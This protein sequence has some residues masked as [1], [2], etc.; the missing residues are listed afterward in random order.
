MHLAE[1]LAEAAA[2]DCTTL[3]LLDKMAAELRRLEGC[4]ASL[5]TCVNVQ[6]HLSTLEECEKACMQLSPDVGRY[7]SDLI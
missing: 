2:D 3:T 6:T 4:I 5:K 1:R 7:R